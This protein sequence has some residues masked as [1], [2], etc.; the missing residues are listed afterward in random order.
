ML[1]RNVAHCHESIVA[2]PTTTQGLDGWYAE[3][4]AG[5]ENIFQFLRVDVH[6]RLTPTQDGM[7]PNWGIRLGMSIEL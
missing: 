4:V 5:I 6:Q 7:L 2:M 3:G 1:N